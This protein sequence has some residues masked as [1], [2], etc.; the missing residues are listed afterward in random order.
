MNLLPWVAAAVVLVA[1]FYIAYYKKDPAIHGNDWVAAPPKAPPPADLTV[2]EFVQSLE[3]HA[4]EVYKEWQASQSGAPE[5]TNEPPPPA[6]T[7]LNNVIE[8]L[9]DQ[10]PGFREAL[11]A[12]RQAL[13][14][15]APEATDELLPPADKSDDQTVP[16]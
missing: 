13:A 3:T 2:Q 11:N 8:K 15:R 6:N 5:A 10:R 12:Q 4:P 7:T 16:A 9:C 14:S 1:L